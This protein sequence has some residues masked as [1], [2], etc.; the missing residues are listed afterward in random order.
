M[1]ASILS[2]FSRRGREGF[3][4]LALG[5]LLQLFT[6]RARAAEAFAG[7]T[8]LAPRDG[9]RLLTGGG[10]QARS[11]FHT[12]AVEL[13]IV[14]GTWSAPH[15]G[16]T[17]S[18]PDGSTVAW[19]ATSAKADGTFSF[20]EG[21]GGYLYL[22][23][24][25]D[26]DQVAWLKGAGH[27]M[28]YVNGEPRPGD[29]YRN[30]GVPL[31]IHLHPGTNDLLFVAGRGDIR[32]ELF[33]PAKPIAL[34]LQD[35]TL[36]DL[37]QGRDNHTWGAVII[38]NG[39]PASLFDLALTASTRHGK[40]T[41][42]PVPE[43]L[44]YSIRKA[45][46]QIRDDGRGR[47]N[48]EPLTLTLSQTKPGLRR[49]LD[50]VQVDLRV[51]RPGETY[52]RT[53]VSQI[54]GSVQ[55]FAVTPAY[56]VDPAHPARALVLSLHG[57]S[58][59]ALGQASAYTSK[60]WAQIIAPTNRRP[61]GF[62][63]ED[64]GRRD[65]ME[66]LEIAQRDFG[67]DPSLTY[68]TGHS[69]GGHGTWQIGATCPDR[70]AALG[71]SAGWIS[72]FSYGE[73]PRSES[74]N[75]VLRLL[76]RAAT[77]IDTLVLA[78]NYLHHGIYILHGD[79]DDN[80]PVSEARAMRQVLEGFHRDFTYH[81][82]PGAGH[83]WGNACVDWPPLFDLFA[84]H[85]IPADESVHEVN[86]I[87]ANPGISA[88]SHW[89]FIEA[90][91]HPLA[92]SRVLLRLD[93]DASG[94]SGRFSGVTEN[95]ARLALKPP[96]YPRTGTFNVELDGQQMTNVAVSASKPKL[97]FA[98]E[99]GAWRTVSAPSPR[100]KGPARYGPFKEAFNQRFLMV[101]GTRGTP[102]ENAWALAKARYDAE[103]FWYRG[104]G[105]I[106]VLP[107]S[108]FDP[109]REPDRGVILYGNAESNGAWDALLRD[110]PVQVAAG[111]VRVGSR[112]WQGLDLACLFL[113]PRPGSDTACVG[114][115]SGS[116][117]VGMKLN[118]RVPYFMAGVAFPDCTVF[119]PA[120]L[121]R[122]AD[123]VLAT[124]FFGNDWTV[125]DGDFAGL[126]H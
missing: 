45:G 124:G 74:T 125:E 120:V 93:R 19:Q 59:E 16:D 86:F 88:S 114:V 60:T 51:R 52:K 107:D 66:V 6:S 116:G 106:D 50:S 41:T 55:Y 84:H 56:P 32:V 121:A 72:W 21:R 115:V 77:P 65:A 79:A 103:T 110:S 12:D 118:D 98:R 126:T 1:S 34:A 29:P 2:S 80:V 108:R 54:D 63:W 76:Q 3:V 102:E 112:E 44:P 87:T 96:A 22:P 7:A 92:R 27:S 14:R 15:A 57:A 25:S 85:R 119:D 104:N 24:T 10:R 97:W 123:A 99:S 64:W 82:Q 13:T 48:R 9:L 89:A 83:W 20:E 8:N 5:A 39:T 75:E 78:S 100:L 95:V 58:V 23:V 62:D 122:G 73:A 47:T 42:T 81:E 43:I 68:L 28:V 11:P 91:E 18:L 90:Q 46:F 101:Y 109:K 69:M 71:P 105:S 94:L 70:F 49:V 53:F 111:R 26:R 67:T 113:R 61:Y 4:C 117:L 33:P 37:L 35:T 36:P 38:I 30:P 31:P 40:S 17:V